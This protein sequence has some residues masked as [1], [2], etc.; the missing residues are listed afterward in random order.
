MRRY[1]N[2]AQVPLSLAVFLATDNYDHDDTTISATA[3]LKPVRQLI[4]AERVP[5]DLSMVDVMGLIKSRMGSA[6]HDSIEGSW[7][8]GY[9]DALLKL[10]YPKRV[11]DRVV[12][13][14]EPSEVTDDQIP[15][16]LEQR[17]YRD[18]MGYRVSGKFDFV[19]EGQVEDFKSTS[20]F[21][22]INHTNDEKYILQGSIYRWLNPDII[23]SDQMA[24]RFIFTD[25]QA[26]KAK[27]DAKYPDHPVMSRTFDL[28]P[29][30]ETESYV[31]HKLSLYERY[32]DADEAD[33]PFCSDDDLW[34]KPTQ[35]K[36]YKNPQKRTRATKN[37]DA[38]VDAYNRLAADGH[39]GVVVE[40]K[41]QVVACK[42]CAAFPVCSQKDQ[43]IASGDLL[44]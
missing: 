16:Y 44:L 33:I 32:K 29:L 14:P 38:P 31:R 3:L 41:G 27:T 11:A 25:H 4:L 43:L 7:L 22:W 21:S 30:A 42:Y 12:V 40:D 17:A 5:Q 19:A 23:T 13:N 8:N 2:A 37:F 35:W 18:I 34:R 9:Q 39:V 1:T 20:V 26:F 6:I 36:Y 24:I 28:K 10:G 15:V